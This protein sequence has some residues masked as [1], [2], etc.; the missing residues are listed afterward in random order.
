MQVD[1]EETR[2]ER[3]AAVKNIIISGEVNKTI[4]NPNSLNEC[5]S[6]SCTYALPEH[7]LMS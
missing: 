6:G 1:N 7:Y 5:E 4:E 3:R 2:F